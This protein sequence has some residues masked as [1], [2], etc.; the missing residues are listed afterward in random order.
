MQKKADKRKSGSEG[1]K[2]N[3]LGGTARK[4][5]RKEIGDEKERR[6]RNISNSKR[7]T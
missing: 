1:R 7:G 2:R 4:R 3:S 6:K 5:E